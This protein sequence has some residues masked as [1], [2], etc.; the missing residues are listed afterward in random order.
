MGLLLFW[1]RAEW[2]VFSY[3]EKSL[4]QSSDAENW[5]V[6][7]TFIRMENETVLEKQ[8]Q[9]QEEHLDKLCN[10]FSFLWYKCT[11]SIKKKKK[12]NHGVKLSDG[13]FLLLKW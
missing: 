8:Y 7:E 10:S 5:P 6:W 2:V 11:P 9:I 3:Q 12:K 4:I 1:L 13:S